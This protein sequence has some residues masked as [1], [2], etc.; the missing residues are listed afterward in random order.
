MKYYLA[1]RM[2]GIDRSNFPRFDE[3]AKFL[4]DLN[5]DIVSPS[6]I[7]T[8]SIRKAVLDNKPVEDT[9]GDFLS[10]D[11]KIVADK[12]DGVI[13]LEEWWKSPG[14]RTEAFVAITRSKPLYTYVGSISVPFTHLPMGMAMSFINAATLQIELGEVA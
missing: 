9:W 12:V 2:T 14:A 6:E 3:V 11:V 5:Y 7:D 8:P 10:R 4:R 1:G 13:L